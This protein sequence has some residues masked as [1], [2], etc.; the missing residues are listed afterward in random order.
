M[1]LFTVAEEFN[2]SNKLQ[3]PNLSRRAHRCYNR[4]MNESQ[5]PKLVQWYRNEGD[6]VH[7]DDPICELATENATVDL[8]APNDGTLRQIAKVGEKIRARANVARIDPID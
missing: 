4:V 7:R 2:A 1:E 5:Y 8:V 3:F 6:I